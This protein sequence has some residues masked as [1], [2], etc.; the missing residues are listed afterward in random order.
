MAQ[1][2]QELAAQQ[3]AEEKTEKSAAS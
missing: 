3:A 1:V 2:H